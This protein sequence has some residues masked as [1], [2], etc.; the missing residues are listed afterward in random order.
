[1]PIVLRYYRI[2]A[3]TTYS[4]SFHH[5]A[6]TLLLLPI[7]LRSLLS[8][9]LYPSF[10]PVLIELGII[11]LSILTL[12]VP[13]LAKPCLR[14]NIRKK[15][16]MLP[17]CEQIKELNEEDRPVTYDLMHNRRYRRALGI[18]ERHS[19][20]RRREEQRNKQVEKKMNKADLVETV[21][22]KL[23]HKPT[24]VMPFNGQAGEPAEGNK[25]DS[26]RKDME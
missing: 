26:S 24:T 8:L 23:Q 15:K 4:L 11:A 2:S 3:L 5:L 12:F 1:M 18:L 7:L 9:F 17:F 19:E 14:R 25:S 21:T 10:L 16:S 6:L 13:G 22:E 20:E